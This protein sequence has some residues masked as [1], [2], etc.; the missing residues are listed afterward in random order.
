MNRFY[1]EANRPGE[2]NTSF[3][4]CIDSPE[5]ESDSKPE[6]MGIGTEEYTTSEKKKKMISIIYFTFLAKLEQLLQV[7]QKQK[8]IIL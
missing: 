4:K 1:A 3:L 8:M 5:E 2:L 7:G 6:D